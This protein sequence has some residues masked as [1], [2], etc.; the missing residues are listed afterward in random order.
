MTHVTAKGSG[1]SSTSY[2]V[3]NV[4]SNDPLMVHV[5]ATGEG[6]SSYGVYNTTSSSTPRID[7][8]TLDGDTAGINFGSSAGTRITNTEIIGGISN[9]AAASNNCRQVYDSSLTNIGC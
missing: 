9:D 5:T 6:P 3:Y 8:S 7:S 4:S 1:G 2:G